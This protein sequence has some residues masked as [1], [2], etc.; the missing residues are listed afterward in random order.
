M[1]T[2]T[3]AAPLCAPDRQTITGTVRGQLK[4]YSFRLGAVDAELV[5]VNRLPQYWR[6]AVTFTDVAAAWGEYCLLRYGYHLIS[7]PLEK[8][9]PKW[10]E[11]YLVPGQ[12]WYEKSCKDKPKNIPPGEIAEANPPTPWEVRRAQTQKPS[13]WLSR[14]LEALT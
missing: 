3:I 8:N 11:R 10:A 14:I 12:A 7:R 9:N 5:R 13:G 6:I 4:P 1:K 2:V